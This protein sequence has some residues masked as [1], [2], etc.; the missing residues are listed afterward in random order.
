M[1]PTELED[2]SPIDFTVILIGESGSGKTS[3]INCFTGKPFRID[4][5]STIGLDYSTK[6]IEFDS[7]FHNKKLLYKLVD[8]AGQEKFRSLTRQFYINSD[9]I[10]FVYDVNNR[11]TFEEIKNYWYNDCLQNIGSSSL[12]A[13]AGC[14]IDQIN[15]N[16]YD[17]VT[18]REGE[19][20]ADRIGAIF[21]KISSKTGEGVENFFKDIG[22][23]FLL[24]LSNNSI[25]LDKTIKRRGSLKLDKKKN[26]SKH[27]RKCCGK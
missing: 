10:I 19:E 22:E 23:K 17:Y 13:L 14:K 12:F 3:L 7:K 26:H 16:S 9:A 1:E 5:A 8:T 4:Q 18:D 20:Y 24:N 6:S 21:G 25:I 2:R 11:C 27:K 15:E